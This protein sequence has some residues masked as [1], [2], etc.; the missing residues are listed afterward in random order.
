MAARGQLQI[1]C[2]RNKNYKVRF[3]SNF[4]ITFSTIWIYADDFF[5]VLLKFKMSTT[6]QL[7]F[8]LWAQKLKN[9]KS[10]NIQIFNHIPHDMEKCRLFFKVPL[11]F[12]MAAMD[13]LHNFLWAQ[14]IEVRNNSHF[15]ITLPTIWKCAGNFTEI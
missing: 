2:G 15:T 9:L 3:Y 5:K 4:T 11:K 8:F 7:Y 1:V 6:D 12:K 10:E 14:K 13:E